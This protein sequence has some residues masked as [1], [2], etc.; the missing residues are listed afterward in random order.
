LDLLLKN[1]ENAAGIVA[2]LELGGERVHKNVFLCALLK[3]GW[4]LE[5]EAVG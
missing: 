3:M 5:D 2:G 4:K 1:N